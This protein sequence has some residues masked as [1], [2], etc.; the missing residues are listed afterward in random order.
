VAAHGLHRVHVDR[1]H[2]RALFPVDLDVHEALVHQLR[3]LGILERLVC[4]HVAPVARRVPDGEEHGLVLGAGEL[5]G[6]LTPLVPVDGVVRV[7]E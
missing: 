4:H 1:V 2:V 7:L 6:L 3:G 5:E